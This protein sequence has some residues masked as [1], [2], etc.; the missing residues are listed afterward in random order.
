MTCYQVL[1][2]AGDPRAGEILRRGYERL[3]A[4]A[5]TIE[6]VERRR[7]F[8]D[9]VPSNRELLCAWEERDDL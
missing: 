7:C 8:F 5:A 9:N 4:S 3:K 1:K 2:A 6:D